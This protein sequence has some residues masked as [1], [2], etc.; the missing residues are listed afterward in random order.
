MA[1]TENDLLRMMQTNHKIF[2]K[3]ILQIKDATDEWLVRYFK[4]A[5]LG[6]LDYR[7]KASSK[8]FNVEASRFGGIESITPKKVELTKE[9]CAEIGNHLLTGIV[10][11]DMDSGKP[12]INRW[13]SEIILNYIE[14]GYSFMSAYKLVKCQSWCDTRPPQKEE[15]NGR[16]D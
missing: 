15:Q 10:M 11:R 13:D 8:L 1:W 16:M 5:L 3:E 4:R 14:K 2:G 6:L 12:T 9:K 7:A